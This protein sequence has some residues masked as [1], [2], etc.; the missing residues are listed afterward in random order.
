[1]RDSHTETRIYIR[2][3]QDSQASMAK[4]TKDNQAIMM[5]GIQDIKDEPH[6]L[7]KQMNIQVKVGIILLVASYIFGTLG[8]YGLFK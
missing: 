2:Q 1:M 7:W 4:E 8:S 6:N 5:K 3:I